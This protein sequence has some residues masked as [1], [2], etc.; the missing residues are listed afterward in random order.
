MQKIGFGAQPYLV[1]EHHNAGHRHIHI[2]S[3]N[4][5]R[6]GSRI[7]LHN[8]GR[9]QSEKARKEIEFKLFKAQL[10]QLKQAYKL[11]LVNIGKFNTANQ[12]PNDRLLTFR[13]PSNLPT[14]I[15]RSLN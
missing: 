12:K 15:L 8:V 11:K 2:V 10:Q 13:T 6:A 7:K 3:T 5:Q 4:I 9:N 14:N 1:Y